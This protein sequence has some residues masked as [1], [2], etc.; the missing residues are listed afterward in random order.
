MLKK[1]KHGM[2]IVIGSTLG[3]YLGNVLFVWF[4][5][6]NNPRLYEMY[7]SP[8]YAKIITASVIYGAI[9][10]IE[11]AIQCFVC[12]KIKKAGTNPS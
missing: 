4:D 6:K 5:Y 10:L 9:L 12:Y 7:S 8:W 3:S 1:I 2:H 11:I